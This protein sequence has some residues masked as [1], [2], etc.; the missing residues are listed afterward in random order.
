M[1]VTMQGTNSDKH[2]EVFGNR[3]LRL[4][5]RPK[6]EEMTEEFRGL[7]NEEEV[8]IFYSSRFIVRLKLLRAY[9]SD[10]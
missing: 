7:L 8:I 4:T 3:L 5:F 1:I 2:I 6:R 9:I 10:T